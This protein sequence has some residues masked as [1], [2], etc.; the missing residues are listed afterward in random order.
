MPQHWET[1][2]EWSEWHQNFLPARDLARRMGLELTAG[3]VIDFPS[4]SMFW[5]RP[6]ALKPILGL[7]LRIEDFPAESGQLEDTLAH[8]IERLFLFACEAGG[9]RWAKVCDVSRTGYPET[10]IPIETPADLD[11]YWRRCGFRLTGLGLR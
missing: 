8:V 10:V 9:Y 3:H 7:G 2:R 1:V 5:A 4:G 6:A 11:A